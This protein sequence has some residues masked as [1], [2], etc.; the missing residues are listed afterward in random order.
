MFTH[1]TFSAIVTSDPVGVYVVPLLLA[2]LGIGGIALGAWISA[3]SALRSRLIDMNVEEAGREREF[4]TRAVAAVSELGIATLHVIEDLQR[5]GAELD[6]QTRP[7][8]MAIPLS[9]AL[10]AR[11]EAATDKWRAV[12]AEAQF[13]TAGNLGDAFWSF[14]KQRERV[15][16]AVNRS[17][18]TS[19]LDV[20]RVE[21]DVWREHH[22][23]QL[24]RLLQV[25]KV[26]GRA[27][28][29]HLAHERCLRS[30]T[31][32]LTKDLQLE[33][34]KGEQIV[35]AESSKEDRREKPAT[36]E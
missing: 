13:Y 12:L 35:R 19:D 14:D 28:V 22:A 2:L 27:R 25:D 21:C 32:K 5:R 1:P 34:E 8:T 11:E 26:R 29:Y 36:D 10:V 18:S 23:R 31:K 17:T 20:A 15:V 24:Y 33:M 9:P 4:G 6:A 30:M 16:Q 3:R 7:T